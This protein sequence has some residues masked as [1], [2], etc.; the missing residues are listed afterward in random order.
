MTG[1]VEH[2]PIS[3]RAIVNIRLRPMTPPVSCSGMIC[4]VSWGQR[5]SNVHLAATFG[6]LA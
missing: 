1:D 6:A 5:V 4:T 2:T 3:S